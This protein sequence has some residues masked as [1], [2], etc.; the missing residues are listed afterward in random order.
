M[1]LTLF[2]N[3][4]Y[5]QYCWHG[6][7]KVGESDFRIK[8]VGTMGLLDE[9]ELRLGCTYPPIQH[10]E[11]LSTYRK[12][13]DKA[14]SAG[15]AKLFEK[16]MALSPLACADKLLSWRDELAAA[17]WNPTEVVPDGITSGD[18]DILSCL[19]AVENHLPEGFKTAADRLREL[20]LLLEKHELKDG[21][22]VVLKVGE[23]H[24]NPACVA[25]LNALREKGVQ[26]IKAG[27]ITTP[28]IDVKHF[29][30][31]VDAAIWTVATA[32]T[33]L[34]VCK[35]RKILSAACAAAGRSPVESVSQP[36]LRSVE[37]LFV[38]AM[39]LLLHGDDF[40]ALR[41]YLSS[42]SHP[43]AWELRS[44]LLSNLISQNGL[45]KAHLSKKSFDELIDEYVVKSRQSREDVTKFLPSLDQKLTYKRVKDFCGD[46]SRWANGALMVTAKKGEESQYAAQWRTL[47]SYCDNM[48]YLCADMGYERNAEIQEKEFMTMLRCV[49]APDELSDQKAAVGSV[50]VVSSP[51]GI[52]NQ[53]GSATWVDC[54]YEDH[55]LPLSFLCDED[56]GKLIETRY[57]PRAWKSVDALNFENDALLAGLS[58]IGN[59]TILH[60]DSF[61]GE[62]RQK[63]PFLI[64]S[65][66]APAIDHLA[67]LPYEEIPDE[68]AFQCDTV[69]PNTHQEETNIGDNKITLPK[70]ENTSGLENI[71]TQPYD[72]FLE[73]V[74]KLRDEPES[75]LSTIKG[76]VAHDVIH[77]IYNEAA[78]GGAT[79][80][81][82]AFEKVF[83]ANYDKFF[84]EAVID[85]GLPLCQKENRLEFKRFRH[86]LST[87]SI[88]KLIEILRNSG[89]VIVGSEVVCNDITISEC[90]DERLCVNATIDLVLKNSSGNYVIF[91]FKWTES[92]SG[93]D[94][95]AKQIQNG[96][97]YQLAVYRKVAEIGCVSLATG[98]VDAQA[99]F[100]LRTAELFSASTGF[101]DAKGPIAPLMPGPRTQR[102]SF[103]ETMRAINDNYSK[104]VRNLKSGMV[105]DG[106]DNKYNKNIILKGTLK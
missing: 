47:E 26:V 59:L 21:L 62:S 72:W 102:K 46:L 74:L 105:C 11:L 19:A 42:P 1:N 78:T 63:H 96:E 10:F 93:R 91:D 69:N 15:E 65:V 95:R 84:N 67:A 50:P 17:G 77:R 66:T 80:S 4:A 88:P 81:A 71:F 40:D 41:D 24:M 34:I 85:G 37:H 92:T 38:S 16:S 82:D 101:K 25:V 64:R 52:A 39:K 57:L 54:S 106:K 35:D 90:D 53:V 51:E 87:V 60:C 70:I 61:A 43:L 36:T 29:R 3:P 9:I 104:I 89:L 94:T 58:N 76:N 5:D 98:S 23:G 8:Y 97:D 83:K 28:A 56:V 33:N 27:D 20:P 32:K 75:N 73:S 100:M 45:G 103:D 79:V 18:K 99:F 7:P 44:R 6:D 13:V 68:Y 86:V 2:Y 12:A 31:S 49:Y 55:S 22:K 30:D 48:V 14:I